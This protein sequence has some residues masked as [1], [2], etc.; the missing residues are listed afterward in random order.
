M[1]KELFLITLLKILNLMTYISIFVLF[2][3]FYFE[4]CKKTTDI[5]S[6][7]VNIKSI[8]KNKNIL[9]ITLYLFYLDLKFRKLC[10]TIFL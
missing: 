9:S 6:S 4:Y 1:F 3:P 10:I 5:K 7:T 8:V 2:S